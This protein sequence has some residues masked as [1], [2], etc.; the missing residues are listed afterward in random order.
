MKYVLTDITQVAEAFRSEYEA[1]DGKFYLK[2]E[3]DHPGLAEANNKI[4]EFRDN[5][6][7]LNKKVTDLESSALRYKDMD[8][9]KYFEYK[10]KV[11][12][13]EKQGGVKGAS[14]IEMRIR[15]AVEPLQKQLQDF[16][17]RELESKNALAKK[18]LEVR[19]REAASKT[20]VADSAVSDFIA[21]GL[22]VFNLEGRA[23]RG[24]T[25]LFSKS[26]PADALS[27]EEWATGLMQDAPHLFKK[28]A[29]GGARGNEGGGGNPRT[30]DMKRISGK[31]PLEFGHNLE[32][33]AKGKVEVGI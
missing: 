23:M 29:G 25:P 19:L 8:P 4:A 17:G 12:E 13:F 24:D 11:E 33:I 5:N 16:Q 14:D 26:R 28:S 7:G 3:G 27:V 9:A 15:Q 6:I 22:G 2:L 30:G 10:N 18:D 32:D 21:R 1:R 31:D 20:G